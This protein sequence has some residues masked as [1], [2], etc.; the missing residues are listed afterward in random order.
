MRA[1]P[2]QI[3]R[4]FGTF[5][6]LKFFDDRPRD[7]S[8]AAG[9]GVH[10][11]PSDALIERRS[12]GHPMAL[13]PGGIDAHSAPLRFPRVSIRQGASVRSPSASRLPT[14]ARRSTPVSAAFQ[15]ESRAYTPAP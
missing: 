13:M 14:A 11:M 7:F 8:T 4:A 10:E 5:A 2:C 12:V 15:A 1:S 3:H 6:T 9:L